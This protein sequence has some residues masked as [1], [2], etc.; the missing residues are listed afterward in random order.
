MPKEEQKRERLNTGHRS[1]E[2]IDRTE[3]IV[4]SFLERGE[5][6]DESHD[7]VEENNFKSNKVEPHQWMVTRTWS[8]YW[9]D[10]QAIYRAKEKPLKIYEPTSLE[11]LVAI[12]A[13]FAFFVPLLT[14]HNKTSGFVN[15]HMKQSINLVISSIFVLVGYGLAIYLA[16]IYIG[17]GNTPVFLF[18]HHIG[19]WETF[20]FILLSSIWLLPIYMI[21][22]GIKNASQGEWKKLPLVGK[23]ILAD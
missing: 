22:A 2:H 19:Y 1:V 16:W 20:F 10:R 3:T 23:D 14:R 8:D 7:A 15:F 21:F 12:V 18:G 4:S 5:K 13:Y 9:D 11:K 17:A 6:H